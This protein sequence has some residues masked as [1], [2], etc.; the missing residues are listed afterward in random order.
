VCALIELNTIYFNAGSVNIA[1]V[2]EGLLDSNVQALRIDGACCVEIVGYSDPEA[3][4]EA[5][6]MAQAR[7]RAIYD[8]YV[9][10]GIDPSKLKI[11][12]GGPGG[13]QCG[14]KDDCFRNRRAETRPVPCEGV[15]GG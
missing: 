3:R 6:Q 12:P 2:S 1:G 9:R 4:E 13:Y 14:K 11:V 10:A 15:R 5:L 7:A 8:Y